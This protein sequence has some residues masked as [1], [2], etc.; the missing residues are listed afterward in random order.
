MSGPVLWRASDWPLWVRL[1]LTAVLVGGAM[2]CAL[3]IWILAQSMQELERRGSQQVEAL[4]PLLNA[5]LSGPLMQRD[6]GSLQAILDETRST[7]D[8]VYLVVLDRNGARVAASGLSPEQALPAPNAAFRDD[9][10]DHVFDTAMDLR[11]AGVTYGRVHYGISTRFLA[12][13]RERILHMV[14]YVGL[15]MLGLLLILF[16]MLGYGL[17]RRLSRLTQASRALAA[18]DFEVSLPRDGQDEVGQLTRAFGDMSRQLQQRL[19]ELREG[20][21]RFYAIANYTYDLELWIDPSAQV[22]WV[23]PSAL[24]MVGFTPEEC[25]QM[26]GFP[27][28]LVVEQ[29]REAAF[30]RFNQAL[31]RAAGEGYQF[32]MQRKDGSQFWAAANWHPI[33]DAEQRFL[34]VRASIRDITELKASE[35]RALDYLAATEAEQARMM[36]L[37]SAMN[38]GIL[39]V[40]RDGRTLYHNPAFERLWS[41]QADQL[42]TAQPV[43]DLFGQT[44]DQ[45]LEVD[46]F[47]KHLAQALASRD[48]TSPLEIPLRDGRV[49]QQSSFPVF[50]RDARF[51]GH[52]WVFEDV[53]IERQTAA[54]MLYLA[55]RDTLTGLYNRHRFQMELDRMLA[56]AAR[57]KHPFALLYFDLD[58][59]KAINDHFGH[60]AGDALLIRVAGEVSGL[61]RRHEMLFRLGG[62]EFAVLMPSADEQQALALAERIVQAIAR[63]PFRLGGQVLHISSSLGIALYP[64]HAADQEQLVIRADAAMYQAKQ[65]G[66]NTWRIYSQ[67]LDNTTE[68]VNRLS[69]NERLGRA[70]ERGLFELHF[71]GV[72]H[73]ADRRLAHL[74]ALIRLRD[75]DSGELVPPARFI[76]VAEKSNRILML[77][78]WVLRQ[79]V[80]LLASH[81]QGPAIAV[82]ISG[83]SF[84]DPK[85]PAY[86]SELLRDNGVAPARLIVEI[87]ETAAVS[88]L[89]DAERFI[90]ALREAGCRVCLDDFGAGFA[91]FA[92]LKHIRVDTIKLDGM[93]IRNLPHD[94]DNQVFVRGMVEVARGLGKTT[95]AECVEDTATLDLLTILGVDKAQGYCLDRPQARHPALFSGDEA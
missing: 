66:K 50:E 11:L 8:F 46:A 20:E 89:T 92:Y 83:R 14:F 42:P 9:A 36:A 39:F 69:W 15:G 21:H 80:A 72:Y 44:Q 48:G 74:E 55:E 70:L 62:D 38:L 73:I 64:M 2:M 68:M 12:E 17:T 61:T 22:I 53:T 85:L 90:E 25:M 65:A 63:I 60:T 71:Q 86:I 26:P 32:R 29:D 47:R 52:L 30:V 88:D 51:I 67:D 1:T 34:G 27:L 87:T 33:F 5:A 76:P 10:G 40:G 31:E 84:D 16:G 45:L 41:L 77:D 54:Q 13:S 94:L 18:G 43:L 75:E 78:R 79:V 57:Q 37:L 56:E 49:M 4:G 58:E 95:V 35:Q 59:F 91:S 23:N 24:R 6:Y 3:L 81:P 82:N 7:R 19:A 28:C 93:F